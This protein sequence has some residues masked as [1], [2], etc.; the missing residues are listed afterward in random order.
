MEGV[1]GWLVGSPSRSI[2]RLQTNQMREGEQG[3]PQPTAAFPWLAALVLESGYCDFQEIVTQPRSRQVFS[4]A[5]HTKL[6]LRAGNQ[7]QHVGGRGKEVAG[8]VAMTRCGAMINAAR[9]SVELLCLSSLSS[10]ILPSTVSTSSIRPGFNLPFET[11]FSGEMKMAPTS[12]AQ[13]MMS[14]LVTTYRHGRRP[15]RSRLAPQ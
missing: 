9:I 6:R 14:S 7:V 15:F 11:I 3:R 2:D 5:Q 12:E 4:R 13:T 10:T 1:W 8:E